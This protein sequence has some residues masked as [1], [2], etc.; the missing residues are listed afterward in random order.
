MRSYRVVERL[1][2]KLVGVTGPYG[3]QLWTSQPL[4]KPNRC[5]ACRKDMKVGE[6]A[7]RPM[8]NGRNRADRIC[9][10]CVG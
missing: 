6:S 8:T 1:S 7:F 2:E 10:G 5:A 9:E 4:R 3:R